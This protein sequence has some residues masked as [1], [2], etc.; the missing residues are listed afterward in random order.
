[1]KKEYIKALKAVASAKHPLEMLKCFAVKGGEISATDLE[2]M[3]K[4]ELDN[5]ADEGVLDAT[6]FELMAS[7]LPFAYHKEFSVED[8]PELA[9]TPAGDFATLTSEDVANIIYVGSYIS[10]DAYRPVFC[11]VVIQERN[12]RNYITA[13]DGYKLA[14]TPTNLPTCQLSD[15]MIK[16]FKGV[17]KIG[18]WKIRSKDDMTELTNGEITIYAKNYG[19]NFPS[20]TPILSNHYESVI[21]LT[22]DAIDKVVK[23]CKAAKED[24]KGVLRD[25]Q[26]LFGANQP[27]GLTYDIAEADFLANPQAFILMPLNITGDKVDQAFDFAILSSMLKKGVKSVKIYCQK[28]KTIPMIVEM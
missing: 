6:N 4:V 11:Q 5:S 23:I 17:A 2:T 10:K 16:L 1:M 19:S 8:M 22:T 13:I 3:V 12:G 7:G 25:G 21:T 26:I 15:K 18:Q 28:G 14:T 20:I 27:T 24:A 9:D